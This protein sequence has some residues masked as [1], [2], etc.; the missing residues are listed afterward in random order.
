MEIRIRPFQPSDEQAVIQLWHDCALVVPQN[1]PAKDIARKMQFQPELFLVGEREGEI[2]ATA[3]VGYDGHRGWIN[4]LAVAPSLR[5]S[6]IGR[7]IMDEAEA[8]L[9]T[10]GCAK[11]NLQVRTSNTKVIEFYERIGYKRDDVV[12]LGKRLISDDQVSDEKS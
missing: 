3:M 11:I 1:D 8:R 12:G 5:C 4:Y 7:R 9:K 10:L 2:V 6:G